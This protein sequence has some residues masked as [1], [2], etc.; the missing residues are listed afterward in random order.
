MKRLALFL[1]TLALAMP[2]AAADKL[3]VLPEESSIGFVGEKLI[4]SHEGTFA[5]FDGSVTT[6]KGKPLAVD[7]TI[8]LATVKTDSGRLDNHLKSADFFDVAH[9]P[10]ATFKSTKITPAGNNAYDVE[11]LFTLRGTTNPI[12]FRAIAAPDNGKVKVTSDFSIDRQKWGVAY[13]GAPD[14]LIK[15]DVAIKLALVFPAPR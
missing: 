12:R 14:N 2:L 10:S 4:G 11:G 1:L 7:F 15:D 8:D 13:K 6:D 3:N 9:H 5:K